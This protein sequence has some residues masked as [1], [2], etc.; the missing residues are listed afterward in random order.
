M[1]TQDL[2]ETL[3]IMSEIYGNLSKGMETIFFYL[4]KKKD[5]TEILEKKRTPSD[6]K[7]LLDGLNNRLETT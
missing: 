7:I 4:K 6:M 5:K 3:D 2:E 1:K